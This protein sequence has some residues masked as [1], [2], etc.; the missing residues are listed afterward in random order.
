MYVLRPI[1]TR[2]NVRVSAKKT[3]FVS[4]TEAPGEGNRRFPSM[5]QGP[6]E[7]EKKLNP[8]KKFLMNVFKIEEIDYGKFRKESKWAIRPRSK[9]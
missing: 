5:D 8:I 6:D 7:P 2:P 9:D 1:I 3:D 4:P